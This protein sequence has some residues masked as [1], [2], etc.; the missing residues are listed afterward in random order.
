MYQRS[1]MDGKML[2]W[3]RRILVAITAGVG[4][5]WGM[6]YGSKFEGLDIF[7]AVKPSLP[8]PWSHL[9]IDYQTYEPIYYTLR[10]VFVFL[11]LC[12]RFTLARWKR[13]TAYLSLLSGL[14]VV[15]SVIVV[16]HGEREGPR[17]GLGELILACILALLSHL[18]S[19]A[20]PFF[21]VLGGVELLRWVVRWVR[22][23]VGSDMNR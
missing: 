14:M 13:T 21:I 5:A 20:F 4:F 3:L 8:F 15:I 17:W 16:A 12:L 23:R 6:V 18:F 19:I 22:L 9:P 2:V 10:W 1:G 11:L 7:V